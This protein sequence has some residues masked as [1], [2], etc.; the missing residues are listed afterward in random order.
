MKNKIKAKINFDQIPLKEMNLLMNSTKDTQTL[1]PNLAALISSIT[2]IQNVPRKYVRKKVPVLVQ[3]LGSNNS[4]SNTRKSFF[5]RCQILN[6]QRKQT[7]LP[8]DIVSSI[9]ELCA[10]QPS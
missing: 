8:R 5:V 9:M 7:T 1:H 3:V 6:F 2:S 10:L 4:C